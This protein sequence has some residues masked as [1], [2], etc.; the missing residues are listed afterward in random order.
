[1]SFLPPQPR[2][3]GVPG[4]PTEW[5]APRPPTPVGPPSLPPPP[6]SPPPGPAP[7]PR[8]HR[9]HRARN[10]LAA[11]LV[12]FA[13]MIAGLSLAAFFASVLAVRAE[14]TLSSNDL[15]EFA[16]SV[17]SQIGRTDP[18]ATSDPRTQTA[19]RQALQDPQV[20]QQ[21]AGSPAAGSHSL[22]QELSALDPS[23]GAA[24]SK[25]PI[26]LDTGRHD[27]AVAAHDL[28]I[29]AIAGGAL[30]AML[31]GCSLLLSSRRDRVLRRVGR[32]ALIVSGFAL[33]LGWL[34]PWLFVTHAH[35]TPRSVAAWF[36]T[37]E[38]TAHAVY[39]ALFG[40]GVLAVV[41]ARLVRE[42]RRDAV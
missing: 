29:G 30:A 7:A 19:I 24:L 33:L 2:S 9:A 18:H 27:L 39:L 20:E 21:L 32:W 17:G 5:S 10:L 13:V 6:L 22:N 12:S 23:L 14:S 15:S 28:R 34:V 40:F 37:G 1:V 26:D 41:V 36:Y 35:G 25:S 4:Q 42:S 31:V 8:A 11:V 3:G 38:S 16:Q